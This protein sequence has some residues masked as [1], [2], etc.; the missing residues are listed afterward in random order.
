MLC[1][2]SECLLFEPD[3]YVETTSISNNSYIKNKTHYSY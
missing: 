1:R 3:V 2:Q